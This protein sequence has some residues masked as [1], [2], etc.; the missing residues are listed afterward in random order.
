MF[1]A[2]IGNGGI[3]SYASDLYID[4]QGGSGD[5]YF[6]DDNTSRF[7]FDLGSASPTIHAYTNFNITED[8]KEELNKTEGVEVLKIVSRYRFFVG[9]GKMFNFKEVRK[10]IEENLTDKGN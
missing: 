10:D 4:V 2:P 9:I 8:V 1:S 3:N 7:K 6:Q 5:I